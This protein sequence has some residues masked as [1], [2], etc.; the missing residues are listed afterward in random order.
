MAAGSKGIVLVKGFTVT[1]GYLNNDVA[2]QAAFTEDGWYFTNDA[3]YLGQDGHLYVMGRESDCIMKGS[4]ILYPIWL[5]ND[6]QSVA[7]VEEV[8]VVPVPDPVLHHEICACVVVKGIEGV[9]AGTLHNQTN[10]SKVPADGD[11]LVSLEARLRQHADS[12][13]VLSRKDL[14]E[15]APKYYVFMGRFPVTNTGKVMRKELTRLATHSL[16]L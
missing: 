7:E 13:T 1:E 8:A 2:T 15:M 10:D 3:G 12:L 9:I 14:M 6:L 5:E 11:G 4:Y 16:N